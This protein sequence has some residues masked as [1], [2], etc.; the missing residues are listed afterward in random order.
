MTK[1]KNLYT[2]DILTPHE[3]VI[4]V[5]FL[6]QQKLVVNVPFHLKFAFKLTY[7]PL[8]NAVFDT[9]L[10]ITTKPQ[11]LARN[12]QLP[13][14]GS[15]LRAFQRAIDEVSTLPPTPPKGG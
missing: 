14:I 15:R 2:A 9:C 11:E 1:Q 5:V 10:L 8:K 13:R 7:P 6:Y 4:I 3:R 12:F